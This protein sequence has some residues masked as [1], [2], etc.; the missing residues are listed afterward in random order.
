MRKALY[1]LLTFQFLQF[2]CNY[3]PTWKIVILHSLV[4][5]DEQQL[6][7]KSVEVGAPRKIIL[8]TNIAE[9]SITVPDVKYGQQI[10]IN[11]FL[12]PTNPF[13]IHFRF[14]L[15]KQLLTFV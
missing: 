5:A 14:V 12:I 1:N 2:I 8:S 10:E 7:F 6:I 11:C 3:R 15:S 4:S 9:S 13:N